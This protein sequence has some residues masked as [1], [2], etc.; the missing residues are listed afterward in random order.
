MAKLARCE[1]PH[2]SSSVLLLVLTL[3]M[4]HKI[5]ILRNFFVIYF[6]SWNTNSALF[7]PN[8]RALFQRFFGQQYNTNRRV[9][10]YKDFILRLVDF[11]ETVSVQIAY[12]E[13]PRKINNLGRKSPEFAIGNN[14]IDFCIEQIHIIS[15]FCK[16]LDIMTVW[17][18]IP[19]RHIYGFGCE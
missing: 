14:F 4:F 6:A 7:D 1:N 18:C 10:T 17:W 13:S 5:R 19:G 2:Q 3:L 15:I 8:F 9:C 12:Y 11:T 16:W